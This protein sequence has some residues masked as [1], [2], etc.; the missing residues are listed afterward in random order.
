MNEFHLSNTTEAVVQED[1]Y[2]EFKVTLSNEK[3][4][5]VVAPPI[6]AAIFRL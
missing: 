2:L 6:A 3:L 5:P 4:L 1:L